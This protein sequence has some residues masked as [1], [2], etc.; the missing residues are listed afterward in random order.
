[1]RILRNSIAVAILTVAVLALVGLAF[2]ATG[3]SATSRVDAIKYAPI[4][5]GTYSF[6]RLT[7][8]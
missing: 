6:D 1:M 7:G 8:S 3:A 2:S 5:T 4:N